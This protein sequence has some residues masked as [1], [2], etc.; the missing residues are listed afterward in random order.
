[1]E[2]APPLFLRALELIPSKK[3]TLQR[4]VF[5][6]VLEVHD[7]SLPEDSSDDDRPGSSD[8]SDE[9][10][11]AI[12]GRYA[13]G[14][15]HPWPWVYR[16]VGQWDEDGNWLPSL[17]QHGGGASWSS[18]SSSAVQSPPQVTSRAP[19]AR[20]AAKRPTWHRRRRVVQQWRAVGRRGLPRILQSRPQC[21][22]ASCPRPPSWPIRFRQRPLL[23]TPWWRQPVSPWRRSLRS[24]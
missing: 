9:G 16:L 24:Q 22:Q 8:S 21:N 20:H 1:V 5:V 19:Q 4:R 14:R 7:F 17:P 18:W 15:L 11:D 2:G 12:P 13:E 6:Q 10:G 23:L 3:D